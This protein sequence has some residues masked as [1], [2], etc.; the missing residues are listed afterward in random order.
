M[1][2][3][4]LGDESLGDDGGDY[5]PY[6]GRARRLWRQA[7]SAPALAIAS[8]VVGFIS[9]S[10]LEDADLLGEVALFG[11]SSNQSNLTQLRVSAAVRLIVAVIAI[12]LAVASGLR[13]ISEDFDGERAD[14][15]WVR[16][17]AGAGLVVSVLGALLA[18]ITLIYALQAHVPTSFGQ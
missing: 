5:G 8:L 16:A 6:P 13:L 15:S 14:P 18:A 12:A 7:L 17:A 1:I 4:H 9:L 3:M 2:E 11:G 10:V